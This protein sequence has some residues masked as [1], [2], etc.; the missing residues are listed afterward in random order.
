[1]HQ[2]AESW[3]TPEPVNPQ[4]PLGCQHSSSGNV[5]NQFHYWERFRELESLERGRRS[6]GAPSPPWQSRA[7]ET[8]GW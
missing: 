2:A 7:E 4:I 1:M 8:L 3:Q 6:C 5:I